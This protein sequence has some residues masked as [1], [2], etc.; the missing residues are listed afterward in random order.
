MTLTVFERATREAAEASET[1][2]APTPRRYA[3]CPPTYF[4]VSYRIN[5][6][7]HPD[8]PVD[9]G[10]VLEQWEALRR[11]YES[12]GHDVLIIE[13][14]PGQPDMVFSANGGFIVDGTAITSRFRFPQRRGEEMAFERWFQTQG[15]ERVL[16]PSSINEGEGD[17]ALV[18]ELIL[19]GT[20]FRT[21][22]EA[23]R[24]VQEVLGRPVVTLLLVDPRYYHLDT[25][26]AV[27]DEHQVMYYPG[28]FSAGSRRVLERLVPDAVL[29]STADAAV[30]GLNATSNGHHVVL[31]GEAAGLAKQLADRGYEPVPV[32]V[33]EL[34]KAGGGPKCMTLELRG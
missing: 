21:E 11:T 20:G 13:P 23:H 32:D 15:F 14:L 17:F 33:S 4:D 26:L 6:W 22:P 3:M 9:Q 16:R 24:D 28:A 34:R 30:L 2:G 7:M 18:G 8:E 25:A 19:A 5:P 31:P 29:A 10:R 27:L 12:L 1:S